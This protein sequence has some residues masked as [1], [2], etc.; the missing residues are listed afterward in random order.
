MD[1][2]RG[3]VTC[4]LL[5]ALAAL[6]EDEGWAIAHKLETAPCCSLLGDLKVTPEMIE[7]LVELRSML[8][9]SSFW[10]AQVASAPACPW[11]KGDGKH[12]EFV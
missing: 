8:D 4:K 7:K 6:P 3:C 1:K 12:V 10:L 11:G 2:Q 9:G 5:E